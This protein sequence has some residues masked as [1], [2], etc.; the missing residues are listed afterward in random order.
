[1]ILL[2]VGE[3]KGGTQINDPADQYYHPK[4]GDRCAGTKR[5]VKNATLGPCCLQ[6]QVPV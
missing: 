3:A 5:L 2:P 6:K 1:M 4:V